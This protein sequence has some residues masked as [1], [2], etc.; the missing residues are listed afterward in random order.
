MIFWIILGTASL[1]TLIVSWGMMLWFSH[2]TT[3]ARKVAVRNGFCPDCGA[4]LM[5]PPKEP[6]GFHVGGR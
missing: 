4:S 3:K 2:M 1:T 5:P 6:V